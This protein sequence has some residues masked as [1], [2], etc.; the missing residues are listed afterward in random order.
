MSRVVVAPI[1]APM[2]S[3]TP[4]STGRSTRSSM[5]ASVP[6]VVWLICAASMLIAGLAEQRADPAHHAG[7]VGYSS[8]STSPSARRSKCR[9]LTSTS[10]STWPSPVSV[11]ETE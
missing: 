8:S 9:P 4:G 6:S 1:E 11:P 3:S 10:F 7:A 5:I 2:G